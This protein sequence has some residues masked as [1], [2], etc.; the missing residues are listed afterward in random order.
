MRC[1]QEY[2]KTWIVV[3][4]VRNAIAKNTTGLESALDYYLVFV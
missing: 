2:L 1:L 3:P 4:G